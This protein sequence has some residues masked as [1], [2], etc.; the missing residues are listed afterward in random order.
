MN[1]MPTT[2]L[3]VR[4]S[5]R[6]LVT[7]N[8]GRDPSEI[9]DA[10]GQYPVYGT[11]GSERF[12][13]DYLYDGDSIVLGRK[14]TIERV[15][16]ATGRFWTIDTAYFLSDF[17]DA[18][19]KWLF[20]FLTS[21]DL[22][23]LNEATGVPSLSRDLLYR[24]QVSTPSGSEQNKIAE[25][26]STVDRAIEQTEALIAKQ[27]RTKTGLMQ[28]LLTRG[29]DEDGNLRSEETHQFKDSPLGRIPVEWEPSTLCKLAFFYSGYAFKNQELTE[30]GWRV[31]RISNLHKPDFPYWHYEGPI[32]PSW[33]IRSGD[34]LFSWAGVASSIDCI[35]YIGPDALMNQH[36]Y[37]IKF[38][39]EQIRK[40]VYYFLQFYLPVLRSEIEGGAGQLHLTKAKIQAIPIPKLDEDELNRIVELLECAEER[41]YGQKNQLAKLRSLKT[42]LM[43]DLLTGKV[44]VTPLLTEP[45]EAD[46]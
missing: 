29:I 46:K 4:K 16:F 33:L 24:I 21:V 40:Y 32:K 11:S 30:H 42:A 8:Y 5:L 38:E 2:D 41:L 7:I 37:N 25:V 45:Q 14:G 26:L 22:R 28:D 12:G 15:H 13:T 34:V 20:Y 27:Q 9:L 1:A 6:E 43:Q 19:P 17:Q 39:T 23:S 35:R 31:V 44:R 36:I 3:W 18:F 10:D